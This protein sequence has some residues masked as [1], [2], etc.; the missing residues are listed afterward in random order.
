[1]RRTAFGI[2][3]GLVFA[4]AACGK[5]APPPPPPQADI[6]PEEIDYQVMKTNNLFGAG[7]NFAAEGGGLGAL[8]LA[9]EKEAI[10][11]LEG[12]VVRLP[13]DKASRLLSDFARTRYAD[14]ARILI[15]AP[16]PGTL[17]AEIGQIQSLPTKLAIIDTVG[18]PLFSAKGQV[19]CK[20]M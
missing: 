12:K 10:I 2:A 19:Q 11:K 4:L 8:V 16:I 15:L 7:C 5:G 18:R 3:L 17:P 6:H 13:A 14:G 20:A 1:M 9:Q